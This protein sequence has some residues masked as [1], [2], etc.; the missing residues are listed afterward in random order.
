MLEALATALLVGVINTIARETHDAVTALT[1]NDE[2]L[3]MNQLE[4]G[5]RTAFQAQAAK[6]VMMAKKKSEPDRR[7]SGASSA[8]LCQ[9][10]R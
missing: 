6:E 7:R 2:L 10:S 3:L 5:D 4:A 8:S 1:R 9:S